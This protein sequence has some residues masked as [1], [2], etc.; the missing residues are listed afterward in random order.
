MHCGAHNGCVDYWTVG[1]PGGGGE[2]RWNDQKHNMNTCVNIQ[3]IANPVYL[4]IY[5]CTIQHKALDSI[6]YPDIFTSSQV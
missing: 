5:R 3:L 4:H 1:Q 6:F 2:I